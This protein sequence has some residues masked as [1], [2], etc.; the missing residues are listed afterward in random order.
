MEPGNVPF[1]IIFRDVTDTGTHIDVRSV[2]I[3]RSEVVF[4]RVSDY[5]VQR[6]QIS[7]GELFSDNIL[8]EDIKTRDK[9]MFPENG[10]IAAYIKLP[11]N[12]YEHHGSDPFLYYPRI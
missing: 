12:V 2:V 3:A 7:C 4:R 11:F 1:K 10:K 5:Y 6:Y 8:N 9:F